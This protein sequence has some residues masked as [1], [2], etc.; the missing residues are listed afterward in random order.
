MVAQA[1]EVFYVQY[2]CDSKWLVVLQG[3]TTC[4]GDHI[5]GLTVDVSEMPPFCQK[6]PFINGEGEEDDVHAN[7][8]DHDEGLWENI[9]T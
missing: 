6:M 4:I 9:P 3:R 1:R 2:L 5:D 7:R 8:N